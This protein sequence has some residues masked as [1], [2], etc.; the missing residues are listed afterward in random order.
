MF[1]FASSFFNPLFFPFISPTL[2]HNSVSIF[3][4]F[5]PS[6]FSFSM[7][8]AV[9]QCRLSSSVIRSISLSLSPSHPRPISLRF[10]RSFGINSTY[11]NYYIYYVY[12][13]QMPHSCSFF[14]PH[15]RKR[16][17]DV[18]ANVPSRVKRMCD[19]YYSLLCILYAFMCIFIF[20]VCG[21]Y[22]MCS[23]TF[24]DFHLEFYLCTVDRKSR[25]SRRSFSQLFYLYVHQAIRRFRSERTYK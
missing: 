8:E 12:K 24:S 3:P 19:F 25:K 15:A 18:R 6:Y 11:V 1:P 22:S 23:C 21:G 2:A 5:I 16:D 17:S 7:Y 10:G 13:I 14:S 9:C 4:L 20:V